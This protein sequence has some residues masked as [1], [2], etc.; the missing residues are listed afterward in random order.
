M[1][2][3]AFVVF[4]WGLAKIILKSDNPT[5]VKNGRDYMMWGLI[6]LFCLVALTGIIDFLMVEL[7]F[8]PLQGGAWGILLPGSP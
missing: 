2:T 3:F 4:F 8:D 7:E 1:Y 5:E 6:A